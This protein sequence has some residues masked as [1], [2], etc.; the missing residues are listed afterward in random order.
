FDPVLVSIRSVQ[1]EML[2]TGSLDLQSPQSRL[3]AAPAGPAMSRIMAS[4]NTSAWGATNARTGFAI[5][6]F[7][8]YPRPRPRPG[9]DGPRLNEHE[10]HGPATSVNGASSFRMLARAQAVREPSTLGVRQ[11]PA[12]LARP[13]D[14]TDHQAQTLRTPE[15]VGQEPQTGHLQCSA[16]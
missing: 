16:C 7:L 6:K 3:L 8:S 12:R 15:V 10:N 11:E 9:Q 4:R 14:A 2:T 5:A 13:A 1:A